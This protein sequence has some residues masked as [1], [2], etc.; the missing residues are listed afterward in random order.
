MPSRFVPTEEQRGQV[1]MLAGLGIKQA[2]IAKLVGLHSAA[3]LRKHFRTELLAGP[4]AM[5][6]KVRRTLY[7]MATSGRNQAATMFWLKTRAGWSE[8]G[9]EPELFEEREEPMKF[10][11]RFVTPNRCKETGKLLAPVIG[12]ENNW[13]YW[14]R[15][16]NGE[17][18]PVAGPRSRRAT[19]P[20]SLTA[21]SPPVG[22][23]EAET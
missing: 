13:E 4:M 10:V 2:E 20:K 14:K 21:G 22:D 17:R 19:K 6:V 1:K 16:Q 9:R 3:T 12:E 7:E 5:A 23:G 18:I 11:I 15:G 8:K